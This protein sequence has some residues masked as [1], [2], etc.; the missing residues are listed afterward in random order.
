MLEEQH[1]KL[2]KELLEAKAQLVVKTRDQEVAS[3]RL[4]RYEV[5][6]AEL[7][8]AIDEANLEISKGKAT[9][10]R[11]EAEAVF[12]KDKAQML[13]EAQ[14]RNRDEIKNITSSKN[15]I[16]VLNTNL[17]QSIS[18][19]NNESSRMHVE[20]RQ[21]KSKLLLAEAEA[22]SA[23]AAEKRISDESNQL[24][25]ELSRQGAVLDGVQR[26][27]SSLLLKNNADV[28]SYKLEITTLKEK[29]VSAEKKQESTV[30]DL[31]GK[32]ADQEL[33][34]KELESSRAN[35]SKEAL[36]AKKES[37]VATKNAEAAT[38][39]SSILEGQ[40]KI[41]KKKLGETNGENEQDV[42]SEL[43]A[44][45]ESITADLE[46][47]N[48]EI[49]TWKTR[50]GTYE[51]L[52][53]DSE[54]AV[55]AI[56]EASDATKKSLE[57]INLELKETLERTNTEMLKRKE[58]ITKLTN[59]LSAQREEREKAVNEVKQQIDGF[60]ADAE[61]H[62]KKAEDVE[63]R[64]A[65]VR[66]DASVLQSDL[67][68]A[69]INYEREL[70]LHAAVRTDL[71]TARE[72]SE[73]ANRLRNIAMEEAATLQSKFKVQQSNLEAEKSKYDEVEKKFENK[74]GASRAENALL[75]SQL[76]KINEQIEKLQSR[77]TSNLMGDDSKSDDISGDEEMMRL[78]MNIS[79]LRELVK[80]VRAE[81]DAMQGQLD[82][83]RRST[84]RERTRASVARRNSEELEAELKMVKGSFAKK[85]ENDSASGASLADKL[86]TTEEQSRL[87]GDSNAHLQQ[88]LQE[89]QK[90]LGSTQNELEASQNALKP[91]AE[92][93]KELEADKAALLAEKESLLREINDWKGRVQSLVSTFNQVDPEDHSKVVKK[94]EQLE[95]QVK[96]LEEKKSSAEEETKRIRTLAS[97][98]SS[99]LSQNKQMVENQKK[100]IAKLTAEKAALVKM[101][102]ESSSKKDLDE[103]KE[104]ILKLEKEGETGKIQLKGSTQMNEKLRERL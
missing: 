66:N 27:E 33:Q 100:A 88:Q 87:L 45:L 9:I 48:K 29:L 7:T 36:D 58:V 86:K 19:A 84:E 80:F 21:A 63:R 24:R 91:A 14:Q 6:N 51:K 13:E 50:S 28:E 93:Q 75:H 78:K 67:A 95:K 60:K 59:D 41:A 92:T 71:R 8:K 15:K 31:K 101:Q 73:Q 72:E 43:R 68:G 57:K 62:Q 16:M 104:R 76:E 89:L 44:K 4:M 12:Y 5:L 53:K 25:N 55:S 96:S 85:S 82:A 39:K 99:H 20:L 65:V 103:L 83:A 37:L 56:T 77:G 70:A 54:A 38:K 26:I 98:A 18:K 42:E 1:R 40:L 69:Q 32:I 102:K 79:E 2:T 34:L 81:K 10:A 46:G 35:T 22:D 47:S 52:A 49:E 61:K 23:K 74:I 94:A 64:F 30:V 97:R 3:E 90:N 17:E 11:S